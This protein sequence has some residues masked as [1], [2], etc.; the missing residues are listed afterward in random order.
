M[1][2]KAE[3][4]IAELGG[5]DRSAVETCILDRDRCAVRQRFRQ[6]KIARPIAT[7]RRKR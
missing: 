1:S 3:H 4:L 6:T 5:I 7:R 2:D